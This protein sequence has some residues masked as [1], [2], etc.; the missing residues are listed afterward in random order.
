MNIIKFIDVGAAGGPKNS[1]CK[2]AQ[3]SLK[4]QFFGVE[5]NPIEYNKLV[6]ENKYK[7]LLQTAIG[8]KKGKGILYVTKDKFTSSLLKPNFKVLSQLSSK[9]REKFVVSKKVPVE[10]DSL[11]SLISRFKISPNW[12]KLDV[13]G[14]EGNIL[15]HYKIDSSVTLIIA[16]LSDLPIYENQILFTEVV[17]RLCKDNFRILKTT[18]KPNIPYERDVY[19]VRDYKCVDKSHFYSLACAHLVFGDVR[20]SYKILRNIFNRYRALFLIFKFYFYCFINKL[21]KFAKAVKNG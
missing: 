17:Q 14:L 12:I 20:F 4:F 13:Q 19:F 10:T 9:T 18:Y 7:L 6:E 15:N 5:P 11:N 16:E 3:Q 2:E 8:E 21:L 1:I